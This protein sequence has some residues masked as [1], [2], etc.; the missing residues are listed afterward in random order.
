M[1]APKVSR[2]I[3]TMSMARTTPAQKPRGLSSKTRFWLA[4]L[5]ARPRLGT[6]S[7]ARSVTL[8]VYQLVSLGCVR[9]LW[10]GNSGSQRC[11]E[12]VGWRSEPVPCHA[13]KNRHPLQRLLR[14]FGRLLGNDQGGDLVVG[15]GGNDALTLQLRFHGV[16]ASIDDLLRIDI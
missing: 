8:Q 4:R 15:R 7:W 6:V 5:S 10:V 1:G 3:L 14:R 11:L 12:R 16:R 2:A 9:D 13:K